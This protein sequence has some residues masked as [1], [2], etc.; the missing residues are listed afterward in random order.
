M[1]LFKKT[2]RRPPTRRREDRA[3]AALDLLTGLCGFWAGV[4]S[5]FDPDQRL[6]S[7]GSEKTKRRFRVDFELNPEGTHIIAHN[8]V[9][10][11]VRTARNFDVWGR[12]ASTGE[13]FRTVFAN[14]I[15]QTNIYNISSLERDR[16][17]HIWRIVMETVGWDEGRPCEFRYEISRTRNQLSLRLNRRLISHGAGYELV[18]HVSLTKT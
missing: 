12:D 2:Q 18:S 15:R 16:N 13:L 17:R 1:A 10:G 7:S 9:N 6:V 8:E 11:E 3:T 5:D 14:G 4:R